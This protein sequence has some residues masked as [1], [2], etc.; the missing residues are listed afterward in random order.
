MV[1][2]ALCA[3]TYLHYRGLKVVTWLPWEKFEILIICVGT[4][5]SFPFPFSSWLSLCTPAW[6]C[7]PF[8]L[9]LRSHTIVEYYMTL[10][11]NLTLRGNLCNNHQVTLCELNLLVRSFV[12]SDKGRCQQNIIQLYFI[13]VC[14]CSLL[15]TKINVIWVCKLH[16]KIKRKSGWVM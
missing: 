10:V 11:V 5:R 6:S 15:H 13:L 1:Y 16:T 3:Y 4:S 14:G 9:P 7:G 12:I 2:V 8:Y